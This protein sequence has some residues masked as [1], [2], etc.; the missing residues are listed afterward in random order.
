MACNILIRF[1]PYAEP[2]GNKNQH[3]CKSYFRDILQVSKHHGH[4]EILNS[5]PFFVVAVRLS[6]T[7]YQVTK[8]MIPF[9]I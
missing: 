3:N 4:I 9:G 6:N 1:G 7:F 5:D 2:R 8:N